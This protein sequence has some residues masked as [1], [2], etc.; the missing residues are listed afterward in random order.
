MSNLLLKYVKK[1]PSI[2]AISKI[3]SCLQNKVKNNYENHAFS[4]ILDRNN[5]IANF[6]IFRFHPLYEFETPYYLSMPLYKNIRLLR[7][8]NGLLQDDLAFELGVTQSYYSRIE[9]DKVNVPISIIEKISDLYS[10]S[11]DTLVRKNLEEEPE[12][13]PKKLKLIK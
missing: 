8:I 5:F 2:I 11:I 4:S 13:L 9:R 7:T 6:N 10:I 3:V 1:V 12:L